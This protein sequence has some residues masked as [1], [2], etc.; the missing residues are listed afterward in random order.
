MRAGT[1]RPQEPGRPPCPRRSTE[2]PMRTISGRRPWLAAPPAAHARR[3]TNEAQRSRRSRGRQRLDGGPESPPAG[4]E[5][6]GG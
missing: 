3:R 5:E 1:R 6:E 2:L 4:M